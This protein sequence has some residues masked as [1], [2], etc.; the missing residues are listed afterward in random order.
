MSATEIQIVET[1]FNTWHYETH[2]A[3]YAAA[4]RSLI[5]QL[6]YVI[7]VDTIKGLTHV[8]AT[9]KS[10]CQICG[11][12]DFTHEV[13]CTRCQTCN[14]TGMSPDPDD[15]CESCDGTGEI[16]TRLAASA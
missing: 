5:E 7:E 9:L 11:G 13:N 1:A 16:F 10:T 6:G 8:T 3:G 14:G 2:S 15:A 12:Y 4:F